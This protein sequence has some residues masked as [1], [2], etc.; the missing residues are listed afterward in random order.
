MLSLS[1]ATTLPGEASADALIWRP[2]TLIDSM[3]LTSVP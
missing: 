3:L 1:V 2:L